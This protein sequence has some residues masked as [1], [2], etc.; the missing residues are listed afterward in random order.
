M[1]SIV[2]K[3]RDT[4]T[5]VPAA[6]LMTHRSDPNIL[7][8]WLS[9]L[10]TK[11]NNLGVDF[12]PTVVITDQGNVEISTIKRVFPTANIFYCAWHVLRAW[13]RSCCH[14]GKLGITQ[15]PKEQKDTIRKNVRDV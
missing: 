5:G 15:L 8:N 9:S 11:M 14:N 10:R 12:K 1:F 7:S 4:G 2:I 3:N 6:F 13:E